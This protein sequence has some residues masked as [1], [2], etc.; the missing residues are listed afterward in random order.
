M[1]K[2]RST[3]SFRSS[4]RALA[5]KCYLLNVYDSVKSRFSSTPPIISNSIT[6]LQSQQPHSYLHT[7]RT[8][9]FHSAVD[10]VV[11]RRSV[12]GE[13]SLSYTPPAANG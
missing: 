9:T 6:A 3:L 5:H 2:S 12:T 1:R 4:V 10:T 13:L 7:P 8:V 11:E